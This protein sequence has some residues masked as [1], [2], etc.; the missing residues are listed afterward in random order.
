MG[1]MPPLPLNPNIRSTYIDLNFA[2]PSFNHPGHVDFL[3]GA[4]VYNQIFENGYRV[5][6]TPGHPLAF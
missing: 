4:N 2:D 1:L 3:L 5:S 6:H